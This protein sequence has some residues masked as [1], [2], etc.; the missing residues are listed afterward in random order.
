MQLGK[1]SLDEGYGA[2]NY[3]NYTRF[4]IDYSMKDKFDAERLGLYLKYQFNDKLSFKAKVEFEHG[5]VATAMEFDNQ[6]EFG[7][8]EQQIEKGGEVVLEQLNLNYKFSDAFNIRAGR[9]KVHFNSAQNLDKPSYYFTTQRSEMESA[10]LPNGWYENGV[11]F[12]GIIKNHWRYYAS[13]TSGFDSSGFSS[14]NWVRGGYQTKFEMQNAEALAY[15]ARLDYLFGTNKNTFAGIAGYV[16]NTNANRPKKDL[17]SVAILNAVAH[18]LKTLAV[19]AAR[20]VNEASV[21]NGYKIFDQDLQCTKCHVPSFKTGSSNISALANQKI[22]PFSD[23][24]LHDMGPDLAD[25]RPDYLADGFE[26]KTPPLWGIG[27]T[28]LVNGHTNFRHD[29]IAR[30]LTEAILWHGG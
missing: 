16:G 7:E 28:F 27:L 20:N 23:F 11:E 26:W 17:N 1:F 12:H 18:Y 25:H 30:T 13:I 15:M 4:D 5:G 8:I 2:V 22:Y 24:L 6:E 3:F 10:I 9:L 14:A 21:A 29:G 19:P